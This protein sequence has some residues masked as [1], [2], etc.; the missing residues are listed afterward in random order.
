[1]ISRITERRKEE[2]KSLIFKNFTTFSQIDIDVS[3]LNYWE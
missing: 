3:Y 2:K 1:M